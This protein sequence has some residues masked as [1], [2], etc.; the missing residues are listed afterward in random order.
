M[1]SSFFCRSEGSTILQF[2]ESKM[3]QEGSKGKER[4]HEPRVSDQLKIGYAQTRRRC[5]RK[6]LWTRISETRMLLSYLEKKQEM[7]HW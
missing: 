3:L 1:C 4:R 7:P 5:G 2:R 6:K